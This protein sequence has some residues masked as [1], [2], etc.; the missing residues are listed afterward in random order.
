VQCPFAEASKF[1]GSFGVTNYSLEGPED[2]DVLVC[3]HGLNG[4]RMLFQD[5]SRVFSTQAGYRVLTFDLYGHGL[6]NAPEVSLCPCRRRCRGR[7][8]YD[9]DFFVDQTEQLLTHLGIE[10]PVNLVGFCLGGTVAVAFAKRFP[11]RV[12]RLVLLSPSGFLPK[13]PKAYYLLKALWCVLIPIAPYVVCSCLYRKEKFRKQMKG[14]SEEQIEK[15]WSRFVWSLFVKRG[16]QSASLAVMYR[17]P[18]FSARPL[19]DEVGRHPRPVLLV[20]GDRD[21]LCPVRVADQ[22][23]KCFSN[24]HLHVVRNAEHMALVE[25]PREVLKV[26]DKFLRLSDNADVRRMVS[27]NMVGDAVQ[28]IGETPKHHSLDNVMVEMQAEPLPI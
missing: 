23:K 16:T 8:R 20:W 18:W 2:G 13:I 11:E 26:M 1:Q 28:V 27:G 3:F 14:E 7:A 4:S 5:V 24:V 19:F 9:L 10:V 6:S 17:V 25:R 12:K 15:L 21:S 22:V